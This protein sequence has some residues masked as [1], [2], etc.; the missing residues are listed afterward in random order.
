MWPSENATD[1]RDSSEVIEWGY[2]E[3][4]GDSGRETVT[5][6]GIGCRLGLAGALGKAIEADQP[7]SEY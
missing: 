3:D 6:M 1:P 2:T 7:P 5:T 4:F